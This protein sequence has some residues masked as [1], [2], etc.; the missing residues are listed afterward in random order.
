M[1]LAGKVW[2][3]Y[4][5]NAFLQDLSETLIGSGLSAGYQA[6]FTDM[7]PAEIALS[8]GAGA[9]GAIAMRPVLARAGYAAGRQIDKKLPNLGEGLNSD[10]IF[11]YM[12]LG[13]P[14]NVNMYRAELAKNP[15]DPT[16]RTMLELAEAKY[17]QNFVGPGGVERGTAEGLAGFVGR[18]YG[19]NIAQLGVAVASPAVLSAMGERTP[20]ERKI[21]ALKAE[22]AALEGK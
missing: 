7:S 11:K 2:D 8:T 3:A 1:R 9:A 6:L 13:T 4:K 5:N 18:Q 19:D 21:E 22:L 10:P 14:Q 20:D 16:T 12:A 17:N 15:N